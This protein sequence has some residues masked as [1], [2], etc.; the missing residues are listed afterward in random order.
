MGMYT[1][2]YV[3][4][5]FKSETPEEVLDIVR[6]VVGEFDDTAK[7]DE[8]MEGKPSRLDCLFSNMSYY[9]TNTSC[10]ILTYDKNGENYSLIGKGDLKSYDNEIE[11]FFDL[12][13]PWVEGKFMGYY[14]YEEDEE[15]TLM[16]TWK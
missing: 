13:S 8:I 5:D 7:Y 15:P 1:E 10:K 9:T 11:Y 6:L 3:N 2:V 16:C 14:M 4:V 12:I